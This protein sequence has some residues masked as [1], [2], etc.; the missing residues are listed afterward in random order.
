[1]KRDGSWSGGLDF[2]RIQGADPL[3]QKL[4]GGGTLGNDLEAFFFLI[5]ENVD[6]K[7]IAGS[8]I[9]LAFFATN[10][11]KEKYNVGETGAW[12]TAGVGEILLNQ[13]R[14]YGVRVRVNFGPK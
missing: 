14:F 4:A 6:W 2:P 13:P 10:L 9:D 11:T 12:T 5:Q 1:M 7:G 3:N 8:P